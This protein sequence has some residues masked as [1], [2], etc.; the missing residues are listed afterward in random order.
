MTD[1]DTLILE[2]VQH[3]PVSA[4]KLRHMLQTHVNAEAKNAGARPSDVLA[5]HLLKLNDAGCIRFL[6]KAD[7]WARVNGAR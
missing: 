1:L 7:G 6:A 4:M 5:K 3:T 2:A